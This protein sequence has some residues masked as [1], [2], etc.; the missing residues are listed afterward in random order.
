MAVRR[1]AAAALL[2]LGTA[3]A[4]A[5]VSAPSSLDVC[6]ELV[7]GDD[8][9]A[10]LSLMQRKAVQ[11][12]SR[13]EVANAPAGVE[14]AE[15][16]LSSVGV[17]EQRGT[18]YVIPSDARGDQLPDLRPYVEPYLPSRAALLETAT[19]GGQAVRH[20]TART[21]EQLASTAG[22]LARS[23]SRRLADG[24]SGPWAR[25]SVTALGGGL[26]GGAQ[27][28]SSGATALRSAWERR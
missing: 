22:P 3:A 5:A 25:D 7:A 1:A 28:L 4:A 12:P 19:E 9:G 26:E 13:Q 18:A 23:W 21:L 17:L 8:A 15:V 24:L 2:L 6:E 10:G 20:A 11:R 16:A 14:D 27:A